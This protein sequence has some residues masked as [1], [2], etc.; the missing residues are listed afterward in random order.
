M[1]VL[2]ALAADP[3]RWRYGYELGQEVGLKAG[4][5]YPILIR[6]TDRGLLD[7]SWETDPPQG[8]PPRHLYRLTGAGVAMAAELAAV[9]AKP[10]TAPRTELRGAW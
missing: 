8:R 2:H 4:S 9:P 6:L 5:L 7:A 3:A 1:A 10:A